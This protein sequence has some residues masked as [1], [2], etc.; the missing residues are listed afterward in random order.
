MAKRKRRTHLEMLVQ[1]KEEE[2]YETTQEDCER[3][4][5]ILNREIFDNLL[6]PVDEIDIGRRKGSYAIYEC[7]D[8]SEDKDYR[9]CKL[10]M[11]DRY[12]SKKMFVE[13]LAHEMVHHYQA[14]HNEPVGHGPSFYRWRDKLNKKGL[15]LV[16]VYKE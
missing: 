16:R 13:V 15:Q 2:L 12:R 9:Y 8:D 1:S 6:E 5:R 10:L 3:W 14:L 7:Y 4:F 11:K